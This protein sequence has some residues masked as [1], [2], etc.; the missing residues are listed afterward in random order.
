MPARL[1]RPKLVD[2]EATVAV[3]LY[4]PTLVFSVNAGAVATPDELVLADTVV[5]EPVKVP[6]G[7]VA[8]AVKVTVAPATGL[9]L[10]SFTVAASAVVKGCVTWVLWPPPVVAVMDAAGPA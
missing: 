2:S 8:G 6:L 10:A 4:D 7:P 1:V 3:T 5:S 9:L